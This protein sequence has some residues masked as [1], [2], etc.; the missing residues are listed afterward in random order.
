MN[1]VMV[2]ELLSRFDEQVRR[3]VSS[4]PGIRVERTSSVVRISGLWSLI[5]Y[6]NL[7]EESADLAIASEKR[8]FEALDEK[9]EWKLYGH[10]RPADL[11]DRLQRA[12]FHPEPLE[13]LL[14]FDLHSKFL[15]A[16]PSIGVRFERVSDVE[17]LADLAAVGE[18]V[19]CV[20][21]LFMN[22]EFLARIPLG[23]VSFHVA[24][25]GSDPVSAGRLEMPSNS[26]FA[27]LYGGGTVPEHRHQGIYRSLV[28]ARAKEALDR[29]YRYLTVDA[30]EASL[31]ILKRLGFFPVTTVRPW[32]WRPERMAHSSDPRARN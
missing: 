18:K 6:S 8:H 7:T 32:V 12:E 16:S 31:P 14:V 17:G 26:E 5:L 1:A 21:Y 4:E 19:F 2:D 3:N 23:T 29:G 28:G 9:V 10:D 13:T 22:D 11:P 24:Y 20:D 15:D 25:R 30:A 27:G